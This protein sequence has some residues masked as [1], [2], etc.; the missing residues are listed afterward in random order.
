MYIIFILGGRMRGVWQNRYR[1]DS[2]GKLLVA[3]VGLGGPE[4]NRAR[5]SSSFF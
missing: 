4:Q 1:V 3:A 5:L 2:Y